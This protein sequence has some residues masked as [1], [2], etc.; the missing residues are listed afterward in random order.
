[1]SNDHDSIVSKLVDD[2][3]EQR[4]EALLSSI[5][6]LVAS[7]LLVIKKSP[8]QFYQ[9]PNANGD[10]LEVKEDI[11]LVLKDQEY[12]KRLEE[13]NKELKEKLNRIKEIV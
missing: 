13:E 6:D 3:H 9:S 10:K 8:I 2:L 7:G 11:R 4:E 12:I 1:M 5:K